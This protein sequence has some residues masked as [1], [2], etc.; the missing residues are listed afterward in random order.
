MRRGAFAGAIVA[1]G[2]A[3]AGEAT[4]GSTRPSL[5]LTPSVAH[6]GESALISGSAGSCPVGDAVIVISRAL[7]RI[8][9]FAGVPAVL[10]PVRADGR[11][12]ARTRVPLTKRPGRYAVTARCGGG[13]F[14]LLVKLTVLR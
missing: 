8:H 12:R 5:V 13:N 14:G 3:L 4:A 6:R 7:P 10:T 1:V 9:E 11:F 2:M